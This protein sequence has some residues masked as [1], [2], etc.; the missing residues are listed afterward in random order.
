MARRAPARDVL[1]LLVDDLG[2][3]G[4]GLAQE[5]IQ[6]AAQDAAGG[7]AQQPIEKF[8]PRAT[9]V[10]CPQQADQIVVRAD[11]RANQQPSE[12]PAQNQ[13]YGLLRRTVERL[14]QKAAGKPARAAHGHNHQDT[15][16]HLAD[17]AE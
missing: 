12:C 5:L 4:P 7:A 8:S 2:V 15:Q 9:P 1:T 17:L 13:E 14:P 3:P 6:D 11:R 16:E 10:A